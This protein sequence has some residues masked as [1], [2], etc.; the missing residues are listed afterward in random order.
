MEL[1]Q[2][3]GQGRVI[4]P[5]AVE[6]GVEL[7]EGAGVGAASVVAHRG[8]DQAARRGRRAADGRLGR[9]D[10]GERILHDNVGDS[11]ALPSLL[12]QLDAPVTG[13]LADGAYDGASTR[14]LLRQRYG[15]TLDV[16]IP[17]PKDAVI[18]LQSARDATVRDRHI[19][20]IRSN[21][22]VRPGT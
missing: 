20:Q 1:G 22:C 8:V 13:F 4:E 10:P 11:T 12:D 6:P 7:A 9:G 21:G 3:G 19:A 14:N 17:P 2:V 16:V 5:A 15:E 18:R